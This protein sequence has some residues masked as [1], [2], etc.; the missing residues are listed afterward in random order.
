[1]RLVIA[2]PHRIEIDALVD[3]VG[4]EGVHGTFTMLPRHIDYVVL[5]ASGILTYV[6]HGEP[7][8]RYV[9]VNGGVL[10][11]VGADVRVATVAAV[12]G[13]RLEDLERTVVRSFRRLD[14]RERD[15]RAAMTRIESHVLHEMFEFEE[16]S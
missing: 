1:M 6:P 12:Q 2:L 4:A 8:E 11:K 3:K 7:D 14:E 16:E 10:T 13:D 9:A 15:T 5:L